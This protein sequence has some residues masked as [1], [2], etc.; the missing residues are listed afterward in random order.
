MQARSFYQLTFAPA[1]PRSLTSLTIYIL[2][3]M[4]SF[5]D[6]ISL[7]PE[8]EGVKESLYEY[9]SA[10]SSGSADVPLDA[11]RSGTGLSNVFCVVS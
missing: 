6:F 11:E 8:S 3:V 9:S 10:S 1:L 7:L 4:D 5:F 2:H